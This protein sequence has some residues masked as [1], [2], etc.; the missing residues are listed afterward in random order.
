MSTLPRDPSHALSAEHS[1]ADAR[2]ASQLTVAPVPAISRPLRR[3]WLQFNMRTM[4]ALMAFFALSMSV[5]GVPVFRLRQQ[6]A[7]SERL[8]KA[9]A[10]IRSDVADGF[11]ER[12][13]GKIFGEKAAVRVTEVS[14]DRPEINAADVTDLQWFEFVEKLD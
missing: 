6:L 5:I 13:A 9:G 4:L 7:A 2:V 10:R 3:R 11:A 8:Q 1:A 14:W 12:L